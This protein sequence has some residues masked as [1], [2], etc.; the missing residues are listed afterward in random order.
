M[1]I[2]Y[3]NVDNWRYYMRHHSVKELR[4]L[5]ASASNA[6]DYL[7]DLQRELPPCE[8]INKGIADLDYKERLLSDLIAERE[9]N[10]E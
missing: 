6:N 9:R 5:R 3:S 1:M 2:D 10:D 4:V 8:V 7:K